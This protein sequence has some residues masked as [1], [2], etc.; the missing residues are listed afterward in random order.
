M[1]GL[2]DLTKIQY[3]GFIIRDKWIGRDPATS[4]YTSIGDNGC[5]GGRDCVFFIFETPFPGLGVYIHFHISFYLCL[6]IY[7][8]I[9]IF[10]FWREK[11]SEYS[12]S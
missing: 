2:I 3:D 1:A 11:G 9:Y 4:L 10:F 8:W 5:S 7:P 12:K 6:S